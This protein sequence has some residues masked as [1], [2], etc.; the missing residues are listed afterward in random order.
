[1]LKKSSVTGLLV[2]LVVLLGVLLPSRLAE[3]ASMQDET[4]VEC[5]PIQLAVFSN[6]VQVR[7]ASPVPG[8]NILFFAAP[9]S[10]ANADSFLTLA[11]SAMDAGG[12]LR[13][14]FDLLDQSGAA[15]RC[16]V[17][18]CRLILWMSLDS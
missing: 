6:R 8:T 16:D 15:L 3:P 18:N 10:A 13:I 11:A 5:D 14:T 17:D 7:C 1:M 9:V 12:T 4:R 2:I